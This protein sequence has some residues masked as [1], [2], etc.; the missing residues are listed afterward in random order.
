MKFCTRCGRE[1]QDDSRNQFCVDCGASIQQSIPEVQQEPKTPVAK[2]SSKGISPF[3]VIIVI[4]VICIGGAGIYALKSGVNSI[5]IIGRFF[6]A[7]SNTEVE[8]NKDAD[9]EVSDQHTYDGSPS[10][11]VSPPLSSDIIA[12][13][14]LPGY[15]AANIVDNNNDTAWAFNIN[16]GNLEKSV[17]IPFGSRIKVYGISLKNGYWKSQYDLI[18]NSRVK[19]L[20]VEFDDGSRELLSVS[21]SILSDFSSMST[22]DGEELVFVQPHR[23]E[24]LKIIITDV[25][26][27]AEDTVFVTGISVALLPMDFPSEN[28]S[29][30]PMVSNDCIL[31]FSS[32]WLL[33]D[34]DLSYLTKDELRLARNEIYARHGRQFNDKELQAYFNSKSWYANIHKLPIGTEPALTDLELSNLD[35]IKA[36][37][38]R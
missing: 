23:T 32:T 6:P 34:A 20:L 33:T 27:G 10:T 28:P 31:P 24:S 30:T 16:E 15:S 38:S 37:E 22:T 21:D 11:E 12:S 8:A 29:N 2:E 5:P 26:Q 3:L 36:Y 9:K 19:E 4:L 35:L 25:Y 7:D 1:Y 17:T 18:R 14:E 13:S